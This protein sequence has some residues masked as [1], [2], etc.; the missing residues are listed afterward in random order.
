[1]KRA[2]IAVLIGCL[3]LC[4]CEGGKDSTSEAE[5]TTTTAAT[6]VTDISAESGS[7]TAV[8][9]ETTAKKETDSFADNGKRESTVSDDAAEIVIG[10]NATS[11][12]VQKQSESKRTTTLTTQTTQAVTETKKPV[13]TEAQTEP[14][15]QAA[16]TTHSSGTDSNVDDGNVMTDDGLDWSPLVPV[17]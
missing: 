10:G 17:N 9:K 14:F 11:V 12:T 8:T 1:M 5:S 2:T 4:G 16:T 13:T 15:Q 7:D 6:A 3:L